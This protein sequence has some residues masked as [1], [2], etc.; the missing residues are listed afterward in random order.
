VV[1]GRDGE[2]VNKAAAEITSQMRRIPLLRLPVSTA[3][4]DRPELRVIPDSERASAVG[5]S[6]EAIAEAVRI[7]TLGDIGPALAK[8]DCADR[9]GPLCVRGGE[10]AR[11]E[12]ALVGARG[13]LRAP[14]GAVPLPWGAP[15]KPA[16]APTSI[17]RYARARR[18]PLG[19]DLVPPAPLGAAV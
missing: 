10:G 11:A 8:F 12:Y 1:T 9:E 3:E 2:A 13:V 18:V 16:Q 4:L 15:F 17:A 5:V 14:G 19:A 6:T 7:A